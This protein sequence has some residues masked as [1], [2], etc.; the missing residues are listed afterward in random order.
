[1]FLQKEAP[2][3]TTGYSTSIALVLLGMIAATANEITLM[4][5]NR[6]RAQVSEEDIRT[7]FTQE[8]LDKQGDKSPLYKY[9]L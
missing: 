5:C 2:L 6:A 1:M 4:R 3:Y 9:T 7:Q 8:E